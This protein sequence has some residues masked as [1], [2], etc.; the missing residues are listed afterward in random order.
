MSNCHYKLIYFNLKGRAEA[1][2]ILFKLANQP[3][4]EVQI[5]FPEWPEL[6]QKTLFR[7]LPIL[8]VTEDSKTTVIAQSNAIIRFLAARFGFSGENDLERAKTD[9]VSEQIRDVFESLVLIYIVKDENEKKQLLDKSMNEATLNGYTLV[10]NILEANTN[11]NGYLVGNK[12]SYADITLLMSYD[13]L[14]DRKDEILS[15]LPALKQ[16]EKMISNIPIIEQHLKE[17]RDVRVT[18]LFN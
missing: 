8:E 5:E 13:W 17:N 18:I 12:I 15:K 4:E 14:R 7:Q 11:G 10:Q 2:R 1:I 6:K 16:H 9:M 3:F